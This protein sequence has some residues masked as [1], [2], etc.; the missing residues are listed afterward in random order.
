MPD[1]NNS[2]IDNV[3]WDTFKGIALI[4]D[5]QIENREDKI[6]NIKDQLE[7][8]RIPLLA[9][10]ELPSDE[11]ID[12]LKGIS[13]VIL[14]WKLNEF[15]DAVKEEGVTIPTDAYLQ[16]NVEFIKKIQGK[17]FCPIFIISN[18]S[19]E[20]IITFLKNK[21][22]IYEDK[23]NFV[24]VDD[25]KINIKNKILEWTKKSNVVYTLKTFDASF[26]EASKE[27]FKSLYSINPEWT[28]IFFSTTEEDKVDFSYDMLNLIFANIKS[29][30]KFNLKTSYF[31]N[32]S[33][34]PNQT[35][36]SCKLKQ[37]KKIKEDIAKLISARTF[38]EQ[39]CLPSNEIQAGDI[40]LIN[41]E[42]YI[43]IRPTCDSIRAE[44]LYLLKGSI[45]ENPASNGKWKESYDESRKHTEYLVTCCHNNKHISFYFKNIIIK[46]RQEILPSRIGRLLHPYITDLQ[47]QFAN[48]I[49]RPGVYRRL[50][51]DM[52]Y[53]EEHTAD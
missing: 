14:D 48:Y 10:K 23:P 41:G 49:S 43:N 25:K 2:N 46:K 34:V 29:R 7:T 30:M 26:F 38:L 13:F 42:Y 9:Y 12:H 35:S 6:S 37:P 24:F 39:D 22:L 20:S 27:T 15:E 31:K 33:P 53:E 50:S 44:E 47:R 21:N 28:N 11:L 52:L 51:F 16:D 18:E 4:I 1:T 8:L 45:R 36:Q 3:I 19:S 32:I 5:D 40:F 17:F